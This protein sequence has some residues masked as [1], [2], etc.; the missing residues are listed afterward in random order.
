M[1]VVQVLTAVQDLAAATAQ[2][3]RTTPAALAAST[4]RGRREL[5]LT[6]LSRLESAR[7]DLRRGWL[8]I[9]TDLHKH[10]RAGSVPPTAA[11]A[12]C[13]QPLLRLPAGARFWPIDSIHFFTFTYG[14]SRVLNK[15]AGVAQALLAASP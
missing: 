12:D 4:A 1:L 6:K 10:V 13:L 2:Q 8:A 3:L 9:R 5:L 7:L 14:A 15:M 11:A